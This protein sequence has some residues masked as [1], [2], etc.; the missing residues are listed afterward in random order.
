MAATH[1]RGELAICDVVA[2]RADDNADLDVL[3]F[4]HLSLDGGATPDEVRTYADLR[5]NGNALAAALIGA[6]LRSEQRR[7]GKEC[8]SRWSPDH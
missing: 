3:T 7:V 4:E 6:G 8:R 2:A 1:T 5:S